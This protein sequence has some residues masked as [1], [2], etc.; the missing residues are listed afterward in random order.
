M[1][2]LMSTLQIETLALGPAATNCYLLWGESRQALVIDPGFEA[3][4][5]LDAIRQN[6]LTVAAYPLTHAHF[7]HV[8]ALAE[9]VPA[10]TAPIGLHDADVS[11]AFS[12]LN[13]FPPYYPPLSTG[14]EFDR[15]LEE[16]QVWEEA[17]L[18]YRVLH[19]PGH[20]PGGVCF[21]FESEGLLIGG[22]CLFAGS[23]G[24]TDLPGGDLNILMKSLERIIRFPDETRVLPGH[25]PETTVGREKESNPFLREI[26]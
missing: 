26:V 15:S 4:R 21:Y 12:P 19:T 25:G 16:G 20:S 5:I 11:V 3:G 10:H 22:D 7:D 23:I 13:Q 9:V 6:K 18:S 1:V 14:V 8:G 17:G 2:V 24:R